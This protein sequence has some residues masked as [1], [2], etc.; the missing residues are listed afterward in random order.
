V[1]SNLETGDDDNYI[2]VGRWDPT[3]NRFYPMFWVWPGEEYVMRLAPS[4]DEEFIGTST[5]DGAS[6]T[7]LRILSKNATC[8]A[9]VDA[10]AS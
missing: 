2:I 6:T 8:P 9:R 1:F 3:T 5:L 4:V 10:Y 7:T